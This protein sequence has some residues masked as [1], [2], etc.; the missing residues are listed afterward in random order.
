VLDRL[1]LWSTDPAFPLSEL[2]RV[3]APALVLAGDDHVFLSI[4]RAAAMQRALPTPSS[5]SEPGPCTPF[6]WR[7][8]NSSSG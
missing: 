1:A 5:R 6:C 2:D 8:T 7:S 3:A 4:E